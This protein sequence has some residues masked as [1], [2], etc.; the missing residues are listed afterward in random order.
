MEAVIQR[1]KRMSKFHRSVP[2]KLGRVFNQGQYLRSM[3]LSMAKPRV[4]LSSETFLDL[5]QN[6][7]V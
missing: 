1:W 7:G 6:K 3:L 4:S 5:S 2:G